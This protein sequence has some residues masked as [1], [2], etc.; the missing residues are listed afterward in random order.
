MKFQFQGELGEVQQGLA[1]LAPELGMELC[2]G[3]TPVQVKKV[4]AGLQVEQVGGG[5]QICYGTKSEFFRAVAQLCGML[6]EEGTV[7]RVS[8]SQKLDTCGIMFDCSRN[9]VLRVDTVKDLLRKMACMGLNM[10]ML[11]TEDTYEIEQYPYFGYMRGAY[12]KEELRDMDQ[13]AVAL[14]IELIPCIQ[15]LGH[16]KM[17]L[18][19]AEMAQVR[20]TPNTLLA[21]EEKT[22]EL[23]AAMLRTFRECFSTKRIHIGMDEAPD[24]GLGTYLKKHGYQDQYS[25]LSRHLERVV[26]LAK[27][28]DFEPMMWSDLF[29]RL[30]SKTREYYDLEAEIPADIEEKIP[31]GLSL[32]YWDY[33][34]S[35][36]EVYRAMM[37]EHQKMGREIVFAG[38]IWKWTGMGVHYEKTFQTTFPALQVCHETGIRHVIAT[39]WGDDGGEVDTYTTLLG[40]QLYA[41]FFYHTAVTMEDLKKQFRRCL[42]LDMEAFLALQ[43]D[44]FPSS[45]KEEKRESVHTTSKQV[46]YQ[47]VLMGLFDKNIQGYGLEE[48]YQKKREILSQIQPPVELVPLFAY[49][50]QLLRVLELKCDLGNQIHEAYRCKNVSKLEKCCGKLDTLLA[51]V[52]CLEERFTYLWESHNKEFGLDR[53]QLRLGGLMMRIRAAKRRIE[54]FLR[55]SIPCIEELEVPQL[56]YEGSQTQPGDSLVGMQL[57]DYIAS[58]SSTAVQ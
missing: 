9:A 48:I 10:A 50:N 12:T 23:I 47:D 5:Y 3:G 22:Y 4:D 52:D 54:A 26:A 24:I 1:Y 31:Q 13:Y 25:I 2:S 44:E 45:A 21:E 11:Y 15:T 30:G 41:E 58:A 56:Y 20:D 43:L 53:V 8:E 55:G 37:Q 18:H 28:Y 40:M 39:M 6:R 33:Y 38:G 14:G 27:E 19:W 51:A 7:S 34:H 17:V 46:L 57:Y 29:F 32:V 49:Q 35:D 36:P 42:G 16:L